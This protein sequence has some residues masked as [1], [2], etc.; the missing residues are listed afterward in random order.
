MKILLLCEGDAETS[1]G[2]FSGTS[3]SIVDGLRAQGHTVVCGNAD[4]SGIPKLL[5][6]AATFSPDRKRWGARYHLGR[7]PFLLRSRAASA[8]ARSAAG[9]SA[10]VVLQIGATFRTDTDRP[11]FLYCD[12]NIRMAERGAKSGFSDGSHLSDDELG[13]VA[14]REATV[15]GAARGVFAISDALRRSFIG[16]F[17]V[18]EDRAFAAYA[19]PN[20]DLQAIPAR[21]D[22]AGRAPTILFV[23]VQFE[24][25]GGDALLRAFA[26][27]RTRHPQARLIVIGPKTFSYQADGVEWWGYLRKEEPSEWKKLVEA[28][29][30]ADVFCLPTRYEPFGIAFVEAMMFGLPCV[31]T[32]T[33]AVPE[34]IQDGTTGFLVEVDDVPALERRLEQL[35]NDAPLRAKLGAAGRLYAREHFTWERIVARMSDSMKAAIGRAG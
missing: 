8:I 16:D 32:R 14:A 2:S 9:R 27:L 21:Q 24:R 10:D 22:V 6:A 1:S 12:S 11:L 23:G 31:G 3:K 4:L 28:Y 13:A 26:N 29:A 7:I 25:K 19:G 33:S 20:L 34:I 35:F 30:D 15:Y 17:S 5:A 18:P